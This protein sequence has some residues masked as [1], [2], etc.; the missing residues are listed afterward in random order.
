MTD[1]YGSLRFSAIYSASL[2]LTLLLSHHLGWQ[3]D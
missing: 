3:E 2:L 1:A